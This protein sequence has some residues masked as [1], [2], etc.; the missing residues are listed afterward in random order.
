MGGGA[1]LSAS[2]QHPFIQQCLPSA[3]F[4]WALC[5]APAHREKLWSSAANEPVFSS[6]APNARSWCRP[7]YCS[8]GW[9]TLVIIEE[10]DS[11]EWVN[12][13]AGVGIRCG[14]GPTNM[15]LASCA[16][17]CIGGLHLWYHLSLSTTNRVSCPYL[18]KHSLR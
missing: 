7:P 16:K 10:E 3:H 18:R 11:L 9:D 1:D 6:Q 17:H 4:V 2:K 5:Q 15:N 8:F 14:G 13:R 12:S